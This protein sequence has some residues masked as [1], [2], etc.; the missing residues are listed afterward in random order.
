MDDLATTPVGVESFFSYLPRVARGLATL[1]QRRKARSTPTGLWPQSHV[2]LISP[3]LMSTEQ[4][5]ELVLK[6]D[7]PMMLLLNGNVSLLLQK[8]RLR[9][10][11]DIQTVDDLG[12]NPVGVESFFHCLPQGCS[13][14]RNPGL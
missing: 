1:G 9:A 8:A 14:A 10:S 2:T 4:S 12:H 11:K 7:F 3:E 5:S 6:D 13:R